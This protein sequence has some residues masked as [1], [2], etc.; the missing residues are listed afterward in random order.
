MRRL[1]AAVVLVAGCASPGTPPGGPV[2]EIPPAVVRITPDSNAVN[3]R[4]GG[5]GIN[6]DE[7]ISERPQGTPDLAD[8][9]L[10]SPSRGRNQIEWHRTRLEVRPRGG[11]KPNTTYRVTMLPG[12][13]DLDG[14]VDSAGV[15][16]VFSTGPTLATG[17]IS[18]R[19]FDWMDEK[20]APRAM[21][22]AIVLPDSQR[23]LTVADSLGHYELHN[24]AAGTYVLRGLVDAN[25]NRDLDPRELYDTLTVTVQDSLKRELHAIPRDTLGPGI[26]RVEIMDSLHLRLRFDRALDTAQAIVP[27]MFTLKKGDSTAITITE[28]IGGRAFKRAQD[29]S[30]RAKAVQDSIRTA[31]DTTRRADTTR[32]A[33]RPAGPPVRRPT[34]AQAAAAARAAA[35]AARTR[36][37]TPVDTT[38][39]P[40]PTVK[41]PD[42]EVI[43]T[44]QAPIPP[45]TPLRVRAEGVRTVVGRTR[46]SER[47]LVS[48]KAAP[49]DT[50][51]TPRDTTAKGARSR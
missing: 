13:M 8:L 27:T 33:A 6:F 44:L 7:V 26:E 12:L 21:V 24:L 39:P 14:N 23:Y 38:P 45:S 3:V 4:A 42:I 41:I 28:A 19:V 20:P 43:L 46:A 5:I 15:S 29:D 11:F 50:T 37:R 9:F 49:V 1:I 22:E 35:A 25:R 16:I 2:D 30:I 31:N 10:I 47:Q 36:P 18:G 40:K 51:R 17:T 48:P 32:A 34:P